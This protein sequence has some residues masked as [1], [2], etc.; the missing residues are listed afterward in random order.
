MLHVRDIDAETATALL[1]VTEKELNYMIRRLLT[2]E[3]LH[4][5]SQ[6]EVELTETGIE[7]LKTKNNKKEEEQTAK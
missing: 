5:I 1:H 4:Y 2:L 3:M 6:D 7:H